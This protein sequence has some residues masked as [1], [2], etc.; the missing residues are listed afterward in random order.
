MKNTPLRPKISKIL[1]GVFEASPFGHGG[2][3]VLDESVRKAM[4]VR[5]AAAAAAA[6]ACVMH[7]DDTRESRNDTV[8]CSHG[9]GRGVS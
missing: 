4:Q 2:Q 3:T 5:Q 1:E 7:D 9:L 6:A 8:G